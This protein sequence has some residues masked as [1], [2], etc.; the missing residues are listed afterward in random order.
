M[1]MKWQW[2]NISSNELKRKNKK[3]TVQTNNGGG[4]AKH[5]EALPMGHIETSIL[6][7]NNNGIVRRIPIRH[8]D[9]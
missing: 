5:S 1:M 9:G 3:Q 4:I 6:I 7:I 2:N 8:F